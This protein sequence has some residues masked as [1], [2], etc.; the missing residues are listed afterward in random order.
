MLASEYAPLFP[1]RFILLTLFLALPLQAALPFESKPKDVKGRK[2]ADGYLRQ[3]AV[4]M[5]PH[6]KKQHFLLQVSRHT[7]STTICVSLSSCL[8]G[9]FG[10]SEHFLPLNEYPHSLSALRHFSGLSIGHSYPLSLH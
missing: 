7:P 9:V 10:W 4:V 3:R 2:K 5:E 1:I 8:R 6:E